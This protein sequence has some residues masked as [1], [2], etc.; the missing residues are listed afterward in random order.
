M[1]MSDNSL[2]YGI[3]K[4]ICKRIEKLSK[5]NECIIA[6]ID[7]RCASGKTTVAEEIKKLCDCNVIHMDHFFLKPEQRSEKRLSEPGGNVD[8][9]RVFKEVLIPLEKGESFSYCP[10]DCHKQRMGEIIHIDLKRINI[11]EGS[12]SCH[13]FLDRFYALK[14]FM[15]VDKE[16]QALRIKNRNGE[17]GYVNFKE[18]WIPLEEKYFSAFNVERG[19]DICFDTTG[20][21]TGDAK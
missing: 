19:C 12:Y 11:I 10:Y 9:E 20:V 14:V 2:I 15:T 3:S 18:K 4:E 7:G 17:S 16:E 8:Y 6:A 13:P 21:K 1:Q 5:G